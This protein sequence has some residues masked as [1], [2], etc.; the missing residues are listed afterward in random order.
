MSLVGLFKP[1]H[2]GTN[3]N[4]PFCWRVDGQLQATAQQNRDHHFRSPVVT[5]N[6]VS[7]E[8]SSTHLTDK[9]PQTAFRHLVR[10]WLG[11]TDQVKQQAWLF[12]GN[13]VVNNSRTVGCSQQYPSEAIRSICLQHKAANEEQMSLGCLC[14]WVQVFGCDFKVQQCLVLAEH[15]TPENKPWTSCILYSV[16]H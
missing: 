1:Q 15:S 11:R 5:A 14:A 4:P 7:K 9:M 10:V 8:P 2:T 16:H 13:S 12:V 3:C 6:R